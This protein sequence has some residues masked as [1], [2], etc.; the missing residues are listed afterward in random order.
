MLFFLVLHGERWENCDITWA[1][2]D[3]HKLF[4]NDV[5]YNIAKTVLEK[6]IKTWEKSAAGALTF[7]DLSPK[8]RTSL[9]NFERKAK[10]DIIFAR[11][12]HGDLESF[13]GPGGIVAHSGYPSDGIVHFDAS[14]H[15]STYPLAIM[16]PFYSNR[17]KSISYDLSKDDIYGIQELYQDCK[18]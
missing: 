4:D 8:N 1:F 9:E 14:L 10:L 3:P 5:D 13:D 18:Q 16:N 12:D 7:I 15:H 2:R 17:T 11:Y 6:V